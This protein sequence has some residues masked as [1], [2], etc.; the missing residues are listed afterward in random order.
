MSRAFGVDL[1]E[2]QHKIEEMVAFEKKIEQ[3]LEHLDH[4]VEGL[5]LTWT[6]QS[7]VAHREAHAEW[8][9]G[10]RAMR[11]GLVEMRD[12]AQRAHDNYTSAAEANS[13]MWAAVR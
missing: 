11:T 1:D 6:G 7:A 9:D 8:V 5:H 2:L 13:R 10:M 3:A 12:A 4:V